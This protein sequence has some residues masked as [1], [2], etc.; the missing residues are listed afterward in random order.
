MF[1]GM[2]QLAVINPPKNVA[3]KRRMNAEF[4]RVGTT[5]GK[6]YHPDHEDE[7]SRGFSIEAYTR[8]RNY[9]RVLSDAL[10]D[11]PPSLVLLE[12]NVKFTR[13][14]A[15]RFAAIMADLNAR[16]PDWDIFYGASS[17]AAGTGLYKEIAP[18]VP[19][20]AS[21]VCF[22]GEV[23]HKLFSYLSEMRDRLPGDPKGGPMPIDEAHGWFRRIH[24][25]YRAFAA[26]P[27]LL[28]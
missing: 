9:R 18:D 22:N 4:R 20:S 24:P 1:D 27:P 11:E 13:D 15:H 5:R 23:P 26:T 19:V 25:E 8:F 21:F 2:G 14:A 28:V 7:A 17:I 10:N 6:F 16:V 3:Q 12:D